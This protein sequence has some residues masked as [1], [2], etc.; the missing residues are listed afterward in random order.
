MTGSHLLDAIGL[1]DDELIREAEEY[2]PPRRDYSGWI[3]LAASFAVV[4]TLGYAL[5]HLNLGMGGGAAPKNEMSGGAASAPAA[6]QGGTV[7]APPPGSLEGIPQGGGDWG[8]PGSPGAADSSCA[9][10]ESQEPGANG[11]GSV[12]GDWL[13]A[14]RADGIVYRATNEYIRLEPEESDIR[15]T[16]SF[17]SGSEPEEDGQAN[18]LPVGIAY[19]VLDDGTAA[20]Y[21]E[22]NDTWCVFDSVPPREK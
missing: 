4:L 13:C 9:G 18:F 6:S 8:E 3:G 17:I 11:G 1:L 14:I 5:S 22:D 15:Y 10:M 19:V 21:H 2:Q 20:V 7:E 16:T 12:T